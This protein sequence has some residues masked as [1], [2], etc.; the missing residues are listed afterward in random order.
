MPIVPFGRAHVAR[1]DDP[2]PVHTSEDGANYQRTPSRAD[3]HA[4]QRGYSALKSVRLCGLAA[5][6]CDGAQCARCSAKRQRRI[7]RRLSAALRHAEPCSAL[8]WTSSVGHRPE[9]PLAALWSE[10]DATHAAVVS[11]GWLTRRADG[12]ARAVEIERA[13]QGW[14]PHAHTILVFRNELTAGQISE[15]ARDLRAR[16]IDSAAKLG[17]PAS[18]AGFDLRPI[19]GLHLSAAVSYL[20]KAHM[21]TRPTRKPGTLTPAMILRD[22]A[23]G[24][25]DALDLMH[26]LDR[27]SFRRRMFQTGGILRGRRHLKRTLA[28]IRV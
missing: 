13:P 5:H 23:A 6:G 19:A 17:I 26:E 2:S 16:W 10:L 25:A 1:S 20:T 24:D 8:L 4:F 3:L 28:E 9:R 15:L 27:A 7:R 12:Y 22:A 14:H 18:A 21:T 11:R